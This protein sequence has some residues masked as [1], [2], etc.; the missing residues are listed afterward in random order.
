MEG[1]TEIS[2]RLAFSRRQLLLLMALFFISWKPGF[3]GSETLQLTT[4]Y[5][6]PYGG[7]ASVLTTGNTIL[8]RD[9]GN[10]SY[11]RI[12][13]GY[14]SG[15]SRRDGNVKL[16]VGDGDLSV[17]KTIRWGTYK[18]TL[19]NDQGGSIELGGNG[20]PYIDFLQNT[21]QDY[22]ARL[23]LSQAGRLEVAGDFSVTGG[24]YN[25]CTRQYYTYGGI[26][27]CPSGQVVGFMGDGIVRVSGYLTSAKTTDPTSRFVALG[28]DWSGTMVC[29]K[30]Y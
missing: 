12:G 10:T 15:N 18:S 21:A 6:A 23:W 26:V 22:S 9:N 7:Y 20:T 1:D 17:T 29:C 14:N 16:E 13:T 27:S 28:Q 25:V 3:L 11:V 5:P 19:S 2:V 4:Y 30:F 24:L 8:A